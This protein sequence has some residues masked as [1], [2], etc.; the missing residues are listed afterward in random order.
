MENR[1]SIVLLL[2]NPT[3]P[4]VKPKKKKKP[5]S[6][7]SAKTGCQEKNTSVG[8]INRINALDSGENQA[9]VGKI[10]S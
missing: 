6:G 3:G 4:Y 7:G 2:Q 9:D 1:I 8:F 10:E 5:K